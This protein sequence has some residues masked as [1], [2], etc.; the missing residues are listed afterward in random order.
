VKFSRPLAALVLLALWGCASNAPRIKLP[1]NAEANCESRAVKQTA[2]GSIVASTD[3]TVRPGAY[4]GD[5]A[6]R[7]VIKSDGK[8]GGGVF[9]YWPNQPLY[10]P[11]SAK[12]L[13]VAGDYLTLTRAVITNQIN[14][15]EHWR[16]IW[17]TVT[18]PKGSVTILERAYDV[19]NVCIEGQRDV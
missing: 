3:D 4:P 8:D 12:T 9:A 6:L 18:T 1:G 5:A 19:Q 11:N 2:I 14:A 13:G 7:R 16:P 10:A 17:L 15:D